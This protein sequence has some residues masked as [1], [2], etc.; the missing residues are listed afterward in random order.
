VKRNVKSKSG[1]VILTGVMI[2]GSVSAGFAQFYPDTVLSDNPV[3]YW[4][5]D[6]NLED[7]VGGNTMDP[8]VGPEFV[9]GPGPDTKA[10]S[11]NAGKAWA[12][13]FGALE[14]FDLTSYSYEMWVNIKGSN[15]GGTYVLMRRSGAPQG[16]GDNSLVFN[17]T[18]GFLE[19]RSSFGEFAGYPPAIELADGTDA[20]HHIAF[21]YDE[22]V[23]AVIAYLDGVEV[24]RAE[25]FLEYILP[26]HDEEIYLGA[27]RT[28]IGEQIFNGEIDEVA[29][30]TH[31]LSAEQIAEHYSASFP[32]EY[33]AKVVADEPKVYWRFEDDF[34]DEM[35]LYDLL[36]SGVRYVPGPGDSGNYALA[37]RVSHF[38]ALN[39]YFFESFSY[40]FWF[41]P[42]GLSDKSYVLFR[43]V[44]GTQQAVIYAYNADRLEY[45]SEYDPNRPGATVPNQT[46]RWYHAVF[47]YD[48]LVPEMRVYL[49]GEP[50]DSKPGAAAIGDGSELHIGGSDQGDN[51]NGYIDEVAIYDYALTEEQIRTHFAAEFEPVSVE[52]WALH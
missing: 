30:Y 8:S 38:D 17:Y 44:G 5:F 20:W 40:E 6:R 12:A 11:T 36:P 16:S 39:L 45:F 51:F 15:E 32:E 2:L 13:A 22:A 46:D 42:I 41:N 19:F 50:V 28:A 49:D 21:V 31:A 18:E 14:L 1:I 48:D 35:G 26:G 52:D 10:F 29:I 24:D 37:G 43:R 23:P 33:P 9:P 25:E 7:A 27:T 47:V 3:S 4:R 34:K